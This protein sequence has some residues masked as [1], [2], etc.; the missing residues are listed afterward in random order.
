[1]IAMLLDSEMWLLE[2]R[3]LCHVYEDQER[4]YVRRTQRETA[5]KIGV[6]QATAEMCA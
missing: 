6:G 1:M 5:T 3:A 2:K 4:A